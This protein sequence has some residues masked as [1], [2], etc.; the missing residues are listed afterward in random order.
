MGTA[1]LACFVGRR[2]LLGLAVALACLA[3][4]QARAAIPL[5]AC[6]STSDGALC[7]TVTVPIDRTGVFPG[8]IG[9][10]VEVLPASGLPRGTMFLIA[11]GPG[12]GSAHVYGL[13]STGTAEFMR[14]MLTG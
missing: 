3:P 8:T 5:A 2:F 9:L 12:Q 13:G 11:G 14:A 10:H 6:S 1:T 7:G 4:G